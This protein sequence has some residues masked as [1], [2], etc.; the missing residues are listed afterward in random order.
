MKSNIRINL[1]KN[2]IP[3]LKMYTKGKVLEIGSGNLSYKKYVNFE[4]YKTLDIDP[5]LKLDYLEDKHKTKVPSN[6][7]NTVIMIEVLEHLY[8][9]FLAI[10]QVHR[11]LKKEG[12][13]IATTPFIHPYHG[14]PHD[15]YRFTSFG[16]KQIFKDFSHIQV[17]K[18]GN[19]FGASTDL[20][21]SYKI[22]KPLKLLNFF[23]N[24]MFFNKFN[25]KT[26]LGHV[27]I[28]KK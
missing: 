21:S 18:Y 25:E 26:P 11:I 17:I 14:E 6:S 7:F 16:L 13:V 5:R 12:C 20:L 24:N 9:P 8:N 3:S 4:K 15:Y 10:E 28:A 22:F 27:I 19:V 1:E 2:L 23:I